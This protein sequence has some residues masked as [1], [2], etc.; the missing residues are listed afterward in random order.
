M[1]RTT[2]SIFTLMQMFP[3]QEAARAYL[4]SQLWPEG[5]H[6]GQATS[7]P[8]RGSELPSS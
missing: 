3:D 2:I 4:E 5:P 6:A 7:L 1:S 8:N